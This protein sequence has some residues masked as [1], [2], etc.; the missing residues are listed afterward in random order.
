MAYSCW[1]VLL[2]IFV[3]VTVMFVICEL[4]LGVR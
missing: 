3:L 4:F 1:N 2:L